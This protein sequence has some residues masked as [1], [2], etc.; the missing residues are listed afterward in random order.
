MENENNEVNYIAIWREVVTAIRE[1]LSEAK[2]QFGIET[3]AIELIEQPART[4]VIRTPGAQEPIVQV[5]I[6]LGGDRLE[7]R[8]QRSIAA[9]RLLKRLNSSISNAKTI[10]SRLF[11]TISIGLPARSK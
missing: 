7:V 11:T 1:R 5:S 10:P 2:E 8:R 6:S 9:G 3:N 4:L